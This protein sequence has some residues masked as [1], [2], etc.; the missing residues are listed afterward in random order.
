MEGVDKF[1]DEG[2]LTEGIEEDLRRTVED[3]KRS[4]A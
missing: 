3:W 1:R 4:F 2:N